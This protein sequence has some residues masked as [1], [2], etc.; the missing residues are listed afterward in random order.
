MQRVLYTYAAL[1]MYVTESSQSLHFLHIEFS[2][3]YFMNVTVC[4]EWCITLSG[5][6]ANV[7]IESRSACY[8]VYQGKHISIIINVVQVYFKMKMLAYLYI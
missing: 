3:L 8:I 6:T 1:K 7:L 2:F 4:A 5:Y